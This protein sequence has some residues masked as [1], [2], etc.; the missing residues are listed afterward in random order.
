[1]AHDIEAPLER[2]GESFLDRVFR[3]ELIAELQARF[4]SERGVSTPDHV[5]VERLQHSLN[6]VAWAL[7]RTPESAV[8][9]VDMDRPLAKHFA[10]CTALR[11][12]EAL[13]YLWANDVRLAVTEMATNAVSPLPEHVLT[14][15][16]LPAPG[17][18]WTWET[19]WTDPE[20]PGVYTQGLLLHPIV[21]A[22]KSHQ[23]LS[24][25]ASTQIQLNADGQTVL[26]PGM[27]ARF[28]ACYPEDFPEGTAYELI[29]RF[30]AFLNS[31]YIP[32]DERLAA[33]PAR[34]WAERV[35]IG[36]VFEP[37]VRFI[38]L[39]RMT[40][41]K[42]QAMGAGQTYSHR[43]LVSGHFRNQWFPSEETHKVIW[44]GP[45]MKGPEGTPLVPRV[46]RVSR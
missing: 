38:L 27:L 44:I 30:L 40:H 31:T 1:L 4:P 9:V 46:Y 24:A 10:L 6:L 37:S 39:R 33:R 23:A 3:P 11:L 25:L 42:G 19:E 32:R 36:E 21:P 35:G 12:V 41:L 8:T 26:R 13:P 5:L 34:R 15:D 22:A 18:W 29:A 28:G 45:Y 20:N 16:I 17:V 43:W 7:E 14:T 2:W